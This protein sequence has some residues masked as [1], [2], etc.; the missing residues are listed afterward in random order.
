MVPLNKLN[1]SLIINLRT[2]K[3]NVFKVAIIFALLT[4][5]LW[6]LISS[7]SGTVMQLINVV[8]ML[9]F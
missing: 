4:V 9:K 7:V 8:R 6:A 2:R 3:L 1:L 5:I